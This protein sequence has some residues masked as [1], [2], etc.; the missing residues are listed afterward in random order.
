MV[1]FHSVSYIGHS[2]LLLVRYNESLLIFRRD[3]KGT[4]G[5]AQSV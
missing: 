1:Y 5:I 3:I 2:S 4:A